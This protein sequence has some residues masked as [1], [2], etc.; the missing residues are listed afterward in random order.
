MKITIELDEG[1]IV[2][3]ILDCFDGPVAEYTD[4]VFDILK[5]YIENIL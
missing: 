2:G 5:K 1:S 3:E 4:Q